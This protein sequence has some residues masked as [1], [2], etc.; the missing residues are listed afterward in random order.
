MKTIILL[1]LIFLTIFSTNDIAKINKLKKEAEKYFFEKNY[2][3]AI[4][5]YNYLLDSMN[6]KDDNV[7]LNLSHS[8][9]LNN[10]TIKFDIVTTNVRA[11][12]MTRACSTL[13][14]TAKAEQIPS[15]CTVI[16]L[17]S[18]SGSLNNF[19]FFFENKASLLII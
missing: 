15:T 5:K 1:C 9:L 3:L 19:L 6:I 4:N 18:S 17:L 8:Y 16:G 13:T 12:V 14:V 10:D 2:E 11:N 7:Q